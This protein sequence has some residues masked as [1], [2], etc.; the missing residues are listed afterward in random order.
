MMMLE[1]Q[2]SWVLVSN[3][4]VNIDNNNNILYQDSCCSSSQTIALVLFSFSVRAIIPM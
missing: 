4:L 2:L 1:E 3:K